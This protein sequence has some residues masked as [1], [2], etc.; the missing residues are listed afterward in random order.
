MSNSKNRIWH[1]SMDSVKYMCVYLVYIFIP[2]YNKI[3]P[4]VKDIFSV[5]LDQVSSSVY[6]WISHI[7]VRY[8]FSCLTHP[9]PG[10][11]HNFLA[12]SLW[13]FPWYIPPFTK[14][15]SLVQFDQSWEFKYPSHKVKDTLC[16][17]Q[18]ITGWLIF[19]HR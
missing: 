4:V 12:N 6:S 15:D 16:K 1:D 10:K 8:Q 18:S 17:E 13:L 5:L 11:S 3:F 9:L 14:C 7:F 19:S 2:A